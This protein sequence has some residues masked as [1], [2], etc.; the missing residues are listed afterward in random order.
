[1]LDK[2]QV[3]KD[4]ELMEKMENTPVKGFI[5]EVMVYHEEN[6]IPGTD[7]QMLELVQ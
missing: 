1:M 6:L 4:A 3:D 5:K 2:K 7:D